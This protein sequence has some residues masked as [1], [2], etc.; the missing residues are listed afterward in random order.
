MT[1]QEEIEEMAVIGCVRNPQAHTAEECSKCDFKQGCCNAYRHAEA[2]YDA[3]YRKVL[4]DI[5]DGK[6][7][8]VVQYA[9][10]KLIERYAKIEVEARE[11][12]AKETERL[13]AENERLAKVVSEKVY[14]FIDNAKEIADARDAWEKQAKIDVLNELKTRHDYAIKNMGYPWD[15]SQQIDK[16]IEEIENNG[17]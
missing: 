13:K 11:R 16:L 17:R 1:R 2:L 8:D 9:P 4:L 3:G 15:I 12:T 14:D 5:K 10:W 7:V 6:A